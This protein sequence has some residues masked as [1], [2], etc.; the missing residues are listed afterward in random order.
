MP[1]IG[2]GAATHA[3]AGLLGRTPATFYPGRTP[4][5]E[6]TECGEETYRKLVKAGRRRI[7]VGGAD[8]LVP[9]CAYLGRLA[10]RLQEELGV[11]VLP[12]EDIG[13]KTAETIAMFG[14]L[15]Q[16]EGAER[17]RFSRLLSTLYRL[18]SSAHHRILQ[19]LPRRRPR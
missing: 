13:L 12:N 14:L 15:R 5:V 4:V 9:E 16:V 19:S 2:L 6:L 17:S 18:A 10:P 7:H 3:I 11:P 1:V 8:V